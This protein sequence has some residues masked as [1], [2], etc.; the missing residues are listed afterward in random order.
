MDKY[1]KFLKTLE[2]SFICPFIRYFRGNYS[3][4]A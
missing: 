4:K 3:V 1:L 2:E